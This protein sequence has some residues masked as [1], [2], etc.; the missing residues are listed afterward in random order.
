MTRFRWLV[1]VTLML[2]LVTVGVGA[3][4]SVT[5][6]GFDQAGTPMVRRDIGLWLPS[7]RVLWRRT[8]EE[9]SAQSI[10]AEDFGIA[11]GRGFDLSEMRYRTLNPWARIFYDTNWERGWHVTRYN[12]DPA[13]R[14]FVKGLIEDEIIERDWFVSD[15]CRI[16]EGDR[17]L[18]ESAGMVFSDDPQLQIILTY[19][20]D[21][22]NRRVTASNPHGQ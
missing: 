14:A 22:R 16:N 5:Q 9:Y 2:L 19:R 11:P 12:R 20:P 21:H 7:G 10:F 8:W 3:L 6:H 15:L 4:T 13:F 1:V 18:S 17:M